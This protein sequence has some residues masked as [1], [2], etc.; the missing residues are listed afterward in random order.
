MRG[1]HLELL[2]LSTVILC[3]NEVTFHLLHLKYFLWSKLSNFVQFRTQN[4][5]WRFSLKS[6]LVPIASQLRLIWPFWNVIVC[7]IIFIQYFLFFTIESSRVFEAIRFE[8]SN[9]ILV[10]FVIFDELNQL[11]CEIIDFFCIKMSNVY[12]R[13]L[14][15][16]QWM[17]YQMHEVI[18]DRCRRWANRA[19]SKLSHFVT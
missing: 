7:W 10:N 2:L 18:Y 17:C 11:D 19:I 15:E 1:H 16:Y 3:R 8:I 13:L 14:Y 5:H 12:G 6:E 9:T 4:H